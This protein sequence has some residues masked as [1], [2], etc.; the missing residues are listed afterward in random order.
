MT[1]II[2]ALV[3]ALG[4]SR[5]SHAAVIAETLALRHRLAVLP[6]QTVRAV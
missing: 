3:G 1:A 2:V 5:G 6:R 4:S